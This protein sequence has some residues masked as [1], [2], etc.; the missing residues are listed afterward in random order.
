MVWTVGTFLNL[1]LREGS[2][3]QAT[4]TKPPVEAYLKKRARSEPAKTDQGEAT[5]PMSCSDVF[6]ASSQSAFGE[7][8]VGNQSLGRASAF[9]VNGLKRNITKTVPEGNLRLL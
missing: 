5:G 4:K 7:S 2:N 1:F 3:L 8:P 6:P 9:R